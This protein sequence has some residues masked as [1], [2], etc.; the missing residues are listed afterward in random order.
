MKT[1]I[2]DIDGT[3]INSPAM[4]LHGLQQTMRRHGKDYAL[5]DL[6]FS[7]GVSSVETMTRLGFTD[8]RENA[9]AIEEW[10]SDSM[11]FADR[12]GW[13]PGFPEV[14]T[15]LRQAGAT[16]GIVTAKSAHEFALDD[17]R[18]HYSRYIDTWVTAGQAK[19]DKPAGDPILLAAQRLNADLDDLLYVGDTLTDAQAAHDAHVAFGLAAWT[20]P[21][22]TPAFAPIAQR[23]TQPRDLLALV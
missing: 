13:I 22:P 1:F 20:T 2:F 16:L 21:K 14:L 5:A 7:N 10:I 23:L 17:A 11:A 4:Y 8:P 15:Q 3:L 9:A 18:Y 12:S 19:R 6:T